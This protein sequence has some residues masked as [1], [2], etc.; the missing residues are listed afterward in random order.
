M[1]QSNINLAYPYSEQPVIYESQ[2]S[3]AARSLAAASILR[4]SPFD[5]V[6]EFTGINVETEAPEMFRIRL[7]DES[8]ALV[9]PGETTPKH[10][11]VNGVDVEGIRLRYVRMTKDLSQID[12]L[13]LT[14]ISGVATFFE[15]ATFRLKRISAG[16]AH[17][18]TSTGIS[19]TTHRLQG[20]ARCIEI[21]S[22]D[23]Q[24]LD[25][26]DQCQ[27][28]SIPTQLVKEWSDRNQR[29]LVDFRIT[30]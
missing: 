20:D 28:D 14:Q 5:P 12:G 9:A 17:L 3:V 21:L 11:I 19:F 27:A 23:K 29:T 26:T 1:D 8:M 7:P 2:T 22:V 16:Q 13:G 10:V 15:P 18:T 6:E 30:L 4:P 24:W 25:V